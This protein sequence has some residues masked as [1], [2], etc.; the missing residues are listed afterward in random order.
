MNLVAL[1]TRDYGMGRITIISDSINGI[2]SYNGK[3]KIS[4]WHKLI[5][6]SAKKTNIEHVSILFIN[7]GNINTIKQLNKLFN[8][9][10]Y[11]GNIHD[12]YQKDIK[13]FDIIYFSGLPSNVDDFIKAEVKKYINNGGCLFIENPNLNNENINIISKIDEV[14][15]ASNQRSNH[16]TAT[17]TRAGRSKVFFDND[18]QI[19]FLS[20]IPFSSLNPKWTILMSNLPS[21][22]DSKE[23]YIGQINGNA[24]EFGI[25][26]ISSQQN[27]ITLLHGNESVAFHSKKKKVYAATKY[28]TLY[29]SFIS[30][31]I[32]VD[33]FIKW[34]N[35]K[36]VKSEHVKL[37]LRTSNSDS[38]NRTRWT[39]LP[40]K[41]DID[42]SNFNGRLLQFMVIV[43]IKED[44]D[45]QIIESIEI[46][47]FAINNA[48]R[49]FTKT[50]DLEYIPK[51]IILTHNAD[52]HDLS[53]INFAISEEESNDPEN[54][55]YI[56]PNKI[57]NIEGFNSDKLK[58]MIEMIS[59]T[60]TPVVLNEFS[61]MSSK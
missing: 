58:I 16:G 53:I 61:V 45:P 40:D 30:N 20:T 37:F 18:V 2:E 1:A 12:I 51:E 17:W 9:S 34:N 31:V 26:F 56:S 41:N 38:L 5:Q 39:I 27:G 44:I 48:V 52:E 28:S 6:W 54:Y 11:N 10:V 36:S 8:C 49:F 46:G 24:S 29:A 19:N 23:E 60:K 42:I 33:N 14:L 59:G 15:I 47:F 57:N 35:L 43:P 4:F 25:S 13:S 32:S 22:K 3:N 50:F 21:F 7:N 55:I